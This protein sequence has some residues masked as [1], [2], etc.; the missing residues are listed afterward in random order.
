MSES[1]TGSSKKTGVRGNGK[2]IGISAKKEEKSKD[3]AKAKNGANIKD[4]GE[5]I[6]GDGLN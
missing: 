3:G 2:S 1:R 6:T 4:E 5:V